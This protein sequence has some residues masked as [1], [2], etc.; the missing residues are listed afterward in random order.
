MG[1][2]AITRAVPLR[3]S[4]TCGAIIP[5]ASIPEGAAASG[6]AWACPSCGRAWRPDPEAIGRVTAA[7]RELR[8]VRGFTGAFLLGTLVVA[9]VL[10]AVHPAWVFG[11]PLLIGGAALMARPTY[12]KRSA[13]ARRALRDPIPLSPA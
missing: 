3:L 10:V 2:R 4:C 9:A 1:A 5:G 11:A 12:R 8:R 13:H 7:V 6:Q